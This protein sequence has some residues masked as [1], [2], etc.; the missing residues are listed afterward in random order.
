MSRCFVRLNRSL[1]ARD[2]DAVFLSRRNVSFPFVATTTRNG[3]ATLLP[4]RFFMQI[5]DL[6][7][8][9]YRD[10]WAEQERAH[11]EVVGGAAERVLLVEHPPVITLGR[12]AG[13]DRNLLAS[14]EQLEAMGVDVVQS[15]RGGDITFHGPG[16]LVV[17]PIIRL[18]DHTLSVGAYVHGLEDA[19]VRL[20][21]SIDLPGAHRDASAVGVWVHPG[22]DLARPAEKVC[23]IGVRI[24]RG[25]TM[26]GLAL[27]VSTDLAFFDL[28]VP[29]GLVS[30]PVTSLARLL[31]DRAPT[32]PDVKQMIAREL[33]LV[34]E[35]GSV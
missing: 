14:P 17:Y 34:F 20:L 8:R 32:M 33:M 25:V 2:N 19:V 23:A 4:V 22:N 1:D 11:A 16:Q 7:T 12:R 18:I 29:C 30:R 3:L 15:D 28:I 26:H 35:R 27:N 24:R 10:A 9:S 21:Q 6:G 5:I 31:G 13:I